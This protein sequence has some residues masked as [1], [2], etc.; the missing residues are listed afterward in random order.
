MRPTHRI[1]DG[2]LSLGQSLSAIGLIIAALL[3]AASMTPSLIPRTPVIQGVVTATCAAT[4]YALGRAIQWLWMFL[5]LPPLRGPSWRIVWW[6]LRGLCAVLAGYALVMAGAW[7]DSIRERFG[8]APIA[9]SYGLVSFVLALGVFLVLLMLGRLFAWVARRLTRSARRYL[10]RRAAIVVSVAATLALFWAIGSGVLFELWLKAM[11]STYRQYD[12]FV[13]EHWPVAAPPARAAQHLTSAQWLALGRNGREFVASGPTARDIGAL[14]GEPAMEPIRV[15]AGLRSAGSP[16]QRAA[17]ALRQL[18]ASGAFERKML[19]VITPTGSGWIDP[20]AIDSV[21][22]LARGDI[23]SVA[24]QY[25]YLSSPLSLLTEPGYGA[26][27]ARALFEAVYGY[28]KQLPAS[29]RPRLYLHGLSLGAMNSERSM[30]FFEVMGAPFQG[31]LWSGPPFGSETWEW[32]TARRNPGTPAWLPT[33]R[34]GNL[35]RFMNQDGMPRAEGAWGATR[36]VYLQYASDAIAFFKPDYLYR[37]PSWMQAPRGPDV[38]PRMHWFPIVTMIQ[39]A[40]DMPMSTVT[41]PSGFGHVYASTHYVDAWQA[42]L[43]EHG[44]GEPEQA[45]IKRQLAGKAQDHAL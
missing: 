2:L 28:W 1:R 38:S 37:R 23:A 4:G 30:E 9:A 21:E 44:L 17:L 12:E 18:I 13:D 40:F 16:A 43:G 20:G 24:V 34:D 14:L 15:Y 29:S 5:G 32:F 10:P 11:D 3:W 26:D 6:V 27:A 25:S 19:V 45:A 7:Q 42:L 31:A 35:V 22:Y 8:L 41:A 36:I 33:F 39:L